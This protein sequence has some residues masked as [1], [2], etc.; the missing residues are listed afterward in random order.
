MTPNERDI[1]RTIAREATGR[2]LIRFST[3]F[4]VGNSKADNIIHLM[5]LG[6]T[7]KHAYEFVKYE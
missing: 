6:V 5:R 4:L 2:Q 3:W 1:I 7:F